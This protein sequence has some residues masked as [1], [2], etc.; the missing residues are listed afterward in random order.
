MP[1]WHFEE[2]PETRRIELEQEPHPRT[3]S[4][5]AMPELLIVGVIIPAAFGLLYFVANLK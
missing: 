3:S 4:E 2:K 5:G 1:V